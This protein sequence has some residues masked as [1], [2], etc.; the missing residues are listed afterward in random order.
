[1]L[2]TNEHFKMLVYTFDVSRARKA[3]FF[4][5]VVAFFRA[6]M[7]TLTTEKLTHSKAD[8]CYNVRKQVL[9]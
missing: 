2:L 1:M 8:E 9:T 4:A 5:I 7:Y 6:I 3:E